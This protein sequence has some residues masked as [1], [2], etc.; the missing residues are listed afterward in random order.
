M[1]LRVT[2]LGCGGSAG[3]PHVGGTDGQGDWGQ[4]DPAE[5]RNRR[6][7]SSIVLEAPDGRLL[8]DTGPELRVQ[9]LAAGIPRV[10]AVFYTH[11]HADHIT[12]LDEVRILN[13]IA[14]QPLDAYGTAYT[15]DEIAHRFDYAFK[16][17]T[18][19]PHF[20]RPVMTRREVVPGDT[21]DVL[22]LSLRVFE[23]DHKVVKT[24]GFRVG[25]FAYSTDLVELGEDALTVLQGVDTWLVGAFQRHPH[26]THA[27]LTRVLGW[28]RDLGVRRTV[29]TH[30]G[31]DMDWGW[32]RAHLPAGVEPAYDTQILA[33]D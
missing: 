9:M 31:I 12:G 15:L 3:T 7:R 26:S 1:T 16:P 18:S 28:A 30:M 13:R 27:S 14:G 17:W 25:D 33:L 24:L 6:S 32:L 22:G 20:F 2:I 29:L 5:P 10:D 11:A 8:V 21:L 19:A 4:C 23:Q